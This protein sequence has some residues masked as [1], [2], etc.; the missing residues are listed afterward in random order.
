MEKEGNSSCVRVCICVC[1][2]VNEFLCS[3]G[4]H[5]LSQLSETL[6][7]PTFNTRDPKRSL[8]A[9]WI[10]FVEMVC[11]KEGVLSTLMLW[12]LP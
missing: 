7:A 1:V 12:Q 9:P 6:L 10:L 4:R 8:W 5:E 2:C 3:V 11:L